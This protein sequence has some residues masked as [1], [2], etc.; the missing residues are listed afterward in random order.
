[1]KFLN[2]LG[3]SMAEGAIGMG[4]LGGVAVLGM[5]LSNMSNSSRGTTESKI[6]S[7]S[8]MSQIKGYLDS[9]DACRITIGGMDAAVG[10]SITEIKNKAGNVVFTTGNKYDGV[11][12][13]SLTL[14]PP[15]PG[16]GS[17]LNLPARIGFVDL[18]AKLLGKAK[19]DGTPGVDI[20]KRARVWVMTNAV[21]SSVIQKCSAG[22]TGTDTLWLR[23]YFDASNI[24]YGDGLIAT[25]GAVGSNPQSLSVMNGKLQVASLD[26]KK[27][28]IQAAGTD[29]TYKI[30]AMEDR[31]IAF[32][33][34]ATTQLADIKMAEL[35]PSGMIRVGPKPVACD[36]TIAGAIRYNSSINKNQVC[37]RVEVMGSVTATT[38]CVSFDN[39]DPYDRVTY[40]L[41]TSGT[42]F[43][44]SS[45]VLIGTSS[46]GPFSGT[47]PFTITAAQSYSGPSTS[48]SF[49][50][51]AG[52]N[53][54]PTGTNWCQS[55]LY[56]PPTPI[57]RD[58]LQ[59]DP[60]DPVA[61]PGVPVINPLVIDGVSYSESSRTTYTPPATCLE[62]AETFTGPAASQL[63]RWVSMP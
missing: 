55:C 25:G 49:Q 13:V 20:T 23:S 12:L 16:T 58:Y 52:G 30:R 51:D 38:T 32:T 40:S 3:F 56:D 28:Q 62:Y 41:T 48:A 42:K 21:G 63:F 19:A 5:Q 14:I 45:P 11:T 53:P 10:G 2:Q 17:Y 33:N 15:V 35:L 7:Q 34:S 61:E 31:P 36:S 1:M 57:V 29:P 37:A 44:P 39:P 59:A 6:N 18:E 60:D 4:L 54:D 50:C 8:L 43:I 47:C 26:D 24:M 27:L 9:D 46:S 22:A